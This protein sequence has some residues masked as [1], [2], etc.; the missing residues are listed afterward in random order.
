MILPEELSSVN[1]SSQ[2]RDVKLGWRQILIECKVFEIKK[3]EFIEIDIQSNRAL[4]N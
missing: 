4:S 3:N 1:Q 2:V